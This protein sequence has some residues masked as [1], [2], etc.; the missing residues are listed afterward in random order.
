MARVPQQERSSATRSRVLDAAVE[1]LLELGYANTTA[2]LVA[3]RAGVS[4]GAMQYHFPTKS[5]LVSA[6]VDHLVERIADDARRAADRLPAGDGKDRIA[7]AIDLLWA[8]SSEPLFTAWLEL[9][10]AARSDPELQALVETVRDRLTNLIREDSFLLVG[11]DSSDV[12][13]GIFIEM[14]LALVS[15]LWLARYTGIGV[16]RN[17]ARRERQVLAAWKE[18]AP[19]LL[20]T[21]KLGVVAGSIGP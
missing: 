3:D 8:R 19:V 10:V 14:T 6:A 5:E 15:G 7:A 4:R 21:N 16:G 2:A 12:N 18:A 13:V 1:S 9:N 11:A 17:R 20:K